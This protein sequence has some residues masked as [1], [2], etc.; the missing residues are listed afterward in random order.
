M[1]KYMLVTMIAIMMPS[2]PILVF[3][4]LSGVDESLS[5]ET[6]QNHIN[7]VNGSC[8]SSYDWVMYQHDASNTGFS[9]TYFPNSLELLWEK[10]YSG[11]IYAIHYPFSSPIIAKGKVFAY[12]GSG[13]R[14]VICALD[15]T[16]GKQ[17]WKKEV[18]LPLITP[19]YLL[20]GY[21]TPAYSNGKLFVTIGRFVSLG[22][23]RCCGWSELLALDENT[24]DTVW[25]RILIGN[26]VYS[27]VTVAEGKV[28]IGVQLSFHLPLSVMYVY[29]ERNGRLLWKKALM[30]FLESTPAV[31]GGKVFV[32]TTFHY[33]FPMGWISPIN[34]PDES[35]VYAFD[36]NNGNKLWTKYIE[37]Y[38]VFSSP[39]ASNG[40]L[41]VPSNIKRSQYRCDRR[42]Y[43][44]DQETGMEIWL[45]EIEQK[46]TFYQPTSISTPSVAYRKVFAVDADG[47]IYVL[48]E[49][50]G[51]EV[52][53]KAIVENHS[54]FLLWTNP[55]ISPIVA[56]GKVVVQAQVE[57]TKERKI[58]L[59]MFNES[60]GEPIWNVRTY[61]DSPSTGPFAL[62]NGK[63]FINN[64][65]GSIY[66]YG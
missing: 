17:L 21:N 40:K 57:E 11:E 14:A 41:F 58:Y 27:S 22:K 50:N 49:E 16:T 19:V 9:S 28:V 24:G 7:V 59:C 60:D 45:Y 26:A 65:W 61:H 32:A 52:W 23:F 51:G 12:G 54:T 63:L 46:H 55:I 6:V 44:L 64:G 48:N 33:I 42:I 66:V 18:K 29:D 37:G 20:S 5:T 39:V 13:K 15:E 25:E 31:S 3:E 47:W 56:D 62:A 10:G 1:L 38:V 8:L 2:Y 30:G 4:R 53:K 35:R 36:L 34:F 43:G